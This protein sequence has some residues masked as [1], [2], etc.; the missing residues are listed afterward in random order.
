MALFTNGMWLFVNRDLDNNQLKELP[1]GVFVN[2]ANLK[3]LWVKFFNWHEQLILFAARL[4]MR[5]QHDLVAWVT[6][7]QF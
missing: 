1:K 5:L 7:Q 2:N 6:S 3:I 4:G